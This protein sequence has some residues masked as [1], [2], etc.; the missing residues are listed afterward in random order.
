MPM[1]WVLTPFRCLLIA[2]VAFGAGLSQAAAQDQNRATLREACLSD[3][4]KYCP[5]MRPGDGRLAECMRAN[6]EKLTPACRQAIAATQS[7]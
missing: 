7:N 3:V 5:G 1:R 4:L 6:S 2:T